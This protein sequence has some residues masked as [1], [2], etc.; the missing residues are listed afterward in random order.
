[1]ISEGSGY[2]EHAENSAFAI[3]KIHFI[4]KFRKIEFYFKS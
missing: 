2:T 3:T 4:L 1:M